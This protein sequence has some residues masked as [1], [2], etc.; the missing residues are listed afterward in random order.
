MWFKCD[1][2]YDFGKIVM[3][4]NNLYVLIIIAVYAVSRTGT[5]NIRRSPLMALYNY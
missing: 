2:N 3:S 5:N 4:R 1:I